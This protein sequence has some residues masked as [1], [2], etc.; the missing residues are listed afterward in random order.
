MKTLEAKMQES[1]KQFSEK[2]E[3]CVKLKEFENTSRQFNLLVEK[4]VIERRGN[5]LLSISDEN[6]ESQVFLN[7][8]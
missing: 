1:I 3:E 4:G 8:K 2:F 7:T 5:N 6:L